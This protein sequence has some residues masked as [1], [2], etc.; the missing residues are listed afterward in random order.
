MREIKVIFSVDGIL[1]GDWKNPFVF[2]SG[3]DKSRLLFLR[4]EVLLAP[5]K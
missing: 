5:V 3:D 1:A 2:F 4:S